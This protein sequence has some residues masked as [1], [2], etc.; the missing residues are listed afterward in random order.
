[1]KR[2]ERQR[3]G[4]AFVVLFLVVTTMLCSF[5]SFTANA[6]WQDFSTPL[7]SLEAEEGQ[8]A[9]QESEHRCRE[10]LYIVFLVNLFTRH[11]QGCE[12]E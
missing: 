8:L 11:K 10:N 6:G 9:G 12:P 2:T 5:F 4:K 7:L 3:F 1:M